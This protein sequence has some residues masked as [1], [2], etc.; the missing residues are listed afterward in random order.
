MEKSWRGKLVGVQDRVA[1]KEKVDEGY[2][3]LFQA[4]GGT[5]THIYVCHSIVGVSMI[6]SKA[7][8]ASKPN[9]AS[10]AK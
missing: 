10:K 4:P 7:S 1:H 2:D 5:P 8:K 6:A 3:I 9:E